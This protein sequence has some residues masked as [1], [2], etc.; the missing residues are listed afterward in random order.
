MSQIFF[1]GQKLQEQTEKTLCFFLREG[2]NFFGDDMLVDKVC[3]APSEQS[4][5]KRV[6]RHRPSWYALLCSDCAE[7]PLALLWYALLCSDC[8]EQ[9]LSTN[10]C[11][12][13]FFAA[14]RCWQ[15]F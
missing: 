7:Q 1:S 4:R 5:A 2:I 12:P 10:M 15:K 3:S 11:Q 8:A 9:P 14:V 6:I 13:F